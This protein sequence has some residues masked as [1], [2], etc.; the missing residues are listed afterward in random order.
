MLAIS[1][2]AKDRLFN[3][4]CLII[5][6]IMFYRGLTDLSWPHDPIRT[7]LGIIFFGGTLGV[8]LM[9]LR[10]RVGFFIF[11][12]LAASVGFIF[13]FIL[14]DIWHHHVLPHILFTAVFLPFYKDMHWRQP[15]R[16]TSP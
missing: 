9:Y 3:A 10:L 16:A 5:G 13:I 4:I 14:E 1:V 8:F 12:I 15:L 6:T 11:A 7:L 2:E